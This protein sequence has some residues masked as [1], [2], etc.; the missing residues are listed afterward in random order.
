M[1]KILIVGARGAN[2]TQ[3]LAGYLRHHAPEGYAQVFTAGLEPAPVSPQ[4]VE[5]MRADGVDIA[6]E[7]T[8]LAEYQ[9]EAFDYVITVSNEAHDRLPALGGPARGGVRK[10]MA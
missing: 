10:P 4:V 9:G 8:H 5:M 1:V 6:E 7:P 2:R 3:M